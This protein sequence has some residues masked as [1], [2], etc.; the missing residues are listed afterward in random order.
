MCDESSEEIKDEL[1]QVDD[2]HGGGPET[3][4]EKERREK[5]AKLHG[6]DHNPEQDGSNEDGDESD[7]P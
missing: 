2:E 6:K 7:S 1:E 4:R 3:D 5:F